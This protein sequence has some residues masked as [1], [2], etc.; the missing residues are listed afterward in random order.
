MAGINACKT[1]AQERMGI[2]DSIERF[3]ADTMSAGDHENDEGLVNVLVS[4]CVCVCVC[5][6]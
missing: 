3:R 2:D 5:V 6:V 4:V 1:L